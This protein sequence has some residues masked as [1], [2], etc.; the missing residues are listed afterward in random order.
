MRVLWEPVSHAEELPEDVGWASEPAKDAVFLLRIEQA[1]RRSVSEDVG[2]KCC[3]GVASWV[4]ERRL[5]E[6]LAGVA[7]LEE[8]RAHI[9]EVRGSMPLPGI[10]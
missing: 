2:R 3:E 8:R 7:Q 1:Q 9:P 6:R 5:R 10:C 4:R